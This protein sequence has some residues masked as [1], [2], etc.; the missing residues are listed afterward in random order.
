MS[1]VQ[2]HTIAGQS[3]SGRLGFLFPTSEQPSFASRFSNALDNIAEGGVPGVGY[4]STP[5]ANSGIVTLG[6]SLTPP[7]AIQTPAAQTNDMTFLFVAKTP[8]VPAAGDANMGVIASNFYSSDSPAKWGGLNVG[9]SSTDFILHANVGP[10]DDISAQYT[11]VAL[12]N[13]QLQAWGLYVLRI[14]SDA[15]SVTATL[16]AVTAGVT[17]TQNWVGSLYSKTD[18]TPTFLL[19]ADYLQHFGTSQSINLCRA[20]IWNA[21]LSDADIDAMTTMVLTDLAQ[22]GINI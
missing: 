16:N 2:T 15:T 13:S 20:F 1:Y 3:A 17:Q 14:A 11:G 6:R 8:N 5:V 12:S 10:S 9:L 19:G 21:A 18:E 22:N 4:L 7:V